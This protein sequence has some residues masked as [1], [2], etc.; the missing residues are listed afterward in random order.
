MFAWI[1]YRRFALILLI[2]GGAV[3]ADGYTQS[4]SAQCPA[5]IHIYIDPRLV[6]QRQKVTREQYIRTMANPWVDK[7]VKDYIFKSY[8]SQNQPIEVPFRGGTVLIS[9]T[10]P[11]IQQY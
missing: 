1:T 4:A 9:P 8:I 6:P 7:N 3:L 5:G 11:C 10:D 2:V